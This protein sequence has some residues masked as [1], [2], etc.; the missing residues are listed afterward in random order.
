MRYN[1]NGS[2]D[3][4]FDGDGKVTTDLGSSDIGT[5][6]TVQAD[7]K[8]LM[9]GYSDYYFV[10]VRYNFD[11]SLDTNFDSDGK[12]MTTMGMGA[13]TPVTVQADGKILL[14]GKL[15][16]RSRLRPGALQ[17]QWLAGHQL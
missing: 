6:V 13:R 10:L 7:G 5:S 3:T 2:L 4:S 15:M 14:G 12:V 16:A 8:I 1:S 11:G 17:Q 9:S